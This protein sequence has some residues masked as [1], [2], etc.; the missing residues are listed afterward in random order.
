MDEAQRAKGNICNHLAADPGAKGVVVGHGLGIDFVL[1][2]ARDRNGNPL[3]ATI[4]GLKSTGVDLR[5]CARTWVTRKSIMPR[6]IPE[7]A[8]VPSGVAEV[9]PLRAR[10]GSVDLRP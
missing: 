1:D 8:I 6:G 2:G 3:E 10:E 5:L 7:S 9:A 4:Q